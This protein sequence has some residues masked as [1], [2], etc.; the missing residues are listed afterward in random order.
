MTHPMEEDL[1]E[2]LAA[3]LASV[4]RSDPLGEAQVAALEAA[5]LLVR[6]DRLVPDD[7]SRAQLVHEALGAARATV[8]ATGIALMRQPGRA[9]HAVG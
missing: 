9:R 6:A 2:G 5:L 3:V 7:E 1:S 4:D 8:V